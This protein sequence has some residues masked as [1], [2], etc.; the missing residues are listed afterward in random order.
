[1]THLNETINALLPEKKDNALSS[2]SIRPDMRFETQNP[3]ETVSILLR[4]HFITNIGWITKTI[5][6]AII[7]IIFWIASAY[8][9][10]NVLHY[11]FM[12]LSYVILIHLVWYSLVFTISFMRFLD[13]YFNIYLITNERVIDFDF[14]PF[15]YHKIAEAGLESIVD[16][17]QEAIG[18]FPMLFNYGDVY[19]QTAGERREFDFR[20]VPNPGW[21]RDKIMDLRNVVIKTQ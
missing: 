20:S 9:D 1:M 16:A 6:F 21:V 8:F 18:F 5:L 13:W 12:K 4:K 19:V 3:N 11:D 2:V 17:T 10:F 14:N 7:P 15:A